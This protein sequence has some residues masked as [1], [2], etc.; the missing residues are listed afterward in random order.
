MRKFFVAIMLLLQVSAL[1]AQENLGPI[2]WM[3]FA[4]AERLDSA[5]S[6]PF[7]IDVYTDWCG[8]CKRMMATTFQNP[9]LASYI[10]QNFYCV[11]FDAE[12]TDTIR[13]QGKEWVHNG[14]VNELAPHLLGNRLSY[15]TIV[16]IDRK[17]N[18][19][20]VPGYMEVNDI[21][22][23]LAYFAEDLS[24]QCGPE[25]FNL[26]YA[27]SFPGIY[28]DKISKNSQLKMDT[29]GVIHWMA[30]DE[31]TRKFATVQKPIIVDVYVDEKY[32]GRV[33][34]ITIQSMVH[35]RA[36]LKD[37]ELA[38]YINENFYPIRIEATTKDSIYWMGR[39]K[40]F[41]STGDGMPN[42]FVNFLTSGNY[43]FPTTVFF[44]K[45]DG[46]NG[47]EL[48]G[49]LSTLQDFYAPGM[50]KIILKFYAEEAYRKE[51]FE[52]FYRKNSNQ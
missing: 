43:K 37:R 18:V 35:E 36:V 26:L 23:F 50:M 5:E 38:D 14:R 1:R 25:E 27:N 15:P 6:R 47:Q 33:P 16:Y 20:P 34:Y 49:R 9:Q 8:W 32:R 42:E 21:E 3:S 51:T 45:F 40:P 22:P 17:K 2:H 12:T 19:L 13:F 44:G 46:N 29:T 52:A 39:S 7:L 11:R 31:V 30:V 41:V 10:N 4:E 28:R 24:S 48:Y